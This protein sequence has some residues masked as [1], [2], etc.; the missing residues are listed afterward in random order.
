[1]LVIPSSKCIKCIFEP[2]SKRLFNFPKN[3]VSVY[4]GITNGLMKYPELENYISTEEKLR[5]DKFH[6]LEDR[7]TYLICH[8]LLRSI[9]SKN[10][11]IDPLEV[12]F[13][14]DM[15]NKP[16]LYGNPLYF[17][18]THVRGAFAF[19]ISKYYTVGI[20]MENV[21]RNIDLVPLIDTI[22]SNEERDFVLRSEVNNLENFFLLWTRKEALLKAIGIGIVANLSQIGVSQNENVVSKKTFDNTVIE[23]VYN[24]YYIYSEKMF[25]YYVSVALPR[26]AE[27][28]FY[29]IREENIISYLN[30]A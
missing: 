12:V 29:Q 19:I 7:N 10:L 3:E 16:G 25:Q 14:Y 17:N 18:I 8:G 13:R 5:A 27:I 21:D 23:I 15:N 24:E 26:K 22:F 28:N 11:K 6:F 4:F 30:S 20:D 2:N 1:M 9:I